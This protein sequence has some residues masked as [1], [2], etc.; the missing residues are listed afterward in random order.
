MKVLYPKNTS[1]MDAKE[2]R[3]K[4]ATF[5]FKF[6]QEGFYLIDSLDVPF[7]RDYST[8]QKVRLIKNGQA[9]LL[10][11]INSIVNKNTKVILISA[12][13]FKADYQ[14]LKQNGINVINE[15]LIDFPGSG[16]QIKFRNKITKILTRKNMM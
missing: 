10:S 11:K 1:L 15:E 3:N 16:G 14:F 8:S 13:V 9:S 4:K 6:K 12:T 5:L 7:N 2:I